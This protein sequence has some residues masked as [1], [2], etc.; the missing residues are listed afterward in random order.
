MKKK[1]NIFTFAACY[2]TMFKNLSFFLPKYFAA[3]AILI[4]FV[5]THEQSQNYFLFLTAV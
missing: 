4:L 1:K 2:G 3:L 5:A